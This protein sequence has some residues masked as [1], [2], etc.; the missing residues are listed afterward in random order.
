[1]PARPR[2]IKEGVSA[3]FL[4]A[5]EQVKSFRLV[6][7]S[8]ER[9]FV[10]LRVGRVRRLSESMP[11]PG[12]RK[13]SVFAAAQRPKRARLSPACGFKAAKQVSGGGRR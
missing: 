11:I 3:C 4:C 5:V 9:Q 1:M 12:P 2:N 8:P 6:S 10:N 7:T 13:M